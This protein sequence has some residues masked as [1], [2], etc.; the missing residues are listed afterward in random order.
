MEVLELLDFLEQNIQMAS[1]NLVGKVSINKKEVLQ[2][3]TEIRSYLPDEFTEA[4]NIVDKRER[5]LNEAKREAEEIIERAR[6]RAQDEYENSDI[7][8]AAKASANEIVELAKKEAK[9][10][11]TE[12]TMHAKEIKYGVM[13]YADG[14]LSN[15]QKEIDLVGEQSLINIKK[16]ME[17]MLINIHKQIASTTSTVRENIKDL[18]NSN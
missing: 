6:R 18:G 2:T 13:N 17:T 16:E 5:I 12:A 1:K 3:I 4:K 14:T 11:K 10:I 9:E 8:T 15:L 7:L